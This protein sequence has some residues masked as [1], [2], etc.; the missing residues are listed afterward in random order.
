MTNPFRLAYTIRV[1]TFTQHVAPF[2]EIMLNSD[3]IAAIA[4]PP[5]EGGIAIVRV[6]GP[7]ALPVAAAVFCA[8]RGG[9]PCG[10]VGYSVHYGRFLDARTGDTVDDG[11]LTVFRAPHS[12][13]GEDGAELSCHGGK[14]T[15]GRVLG[16]VLHAGARLAEPGEFTQ[17]AFLNGR[18]DL[19]QAEAVADLIRAQTETSQR[20]ARRQLDGALSGVVRKLREELIGILAAIE[21]TIDFSDEVGELNYTQLLA[22]IRV[23]RGGIE[24]LLTTADRG[25]IL[26]EGLRVALVGRPNVGKSSLFNTLLR[27]ERAIVT[28]MPGTTRDRL[29]ETANIEGVPLILI[30]LAGLRETSDI[31][32]REGV[33][34]ARAALR[35]CD[36]ALFVLD[37]GA[38]VTE[39]DRA[40]ASSIA[41]LPAGRALT[42][43]NK[44]DTVSDAA[45]EAVSAE[46]RTLAPAADIAAV[47]AL[48]GAGIPDLE[49][50]MLRLALGD[51][52]GA[53]LAAESAIVSSLR[54]RQ[55]LEAA[56]G[57]I[58]EAEQT[59]E[60]A[61]PGDFVAIDARGALDALGL[62]TGETVTDDI[63]HRIFRDFCVGK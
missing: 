45:L 49:R 23:V 42:V 2:V 6:S 47:S 56:L 27:M 31:V 37:A 3:T 18:V 57:S 44:C 59:A 34:R 14:A 13:T 35:E 48:T 51:D 24:G 15:A 8:G 60:Q 54:H 32:E 28:A 25:R 38:G 16:A 21:V 62:V 9:D 63:V 22:R 43:L 36:L 7:G 58:R 20:M 40:A 26:R 55:A 10:F 29:E 30:D 41:A 52:A 33:E 17:R 61:L 46:A 39:A 11:L 19:A 12:Y 4:T 53:G 1:L 50:H 5:G